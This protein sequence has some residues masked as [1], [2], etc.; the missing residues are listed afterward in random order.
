MVLNPLPKFV[1]PD[2]HQIYA[3][4]ESTYMVLDVETTNKDKGAAVNKD[5]HLVLACWEI[6]HPNGHIESK[7]HFGDEW[8]QAEL[9]ADLERVDFVVAQNAKFELQWLSRCGVNLR[10]ILPF[11]TMLGAW[12]LDGNRTLPRHLDALATRYNLGVKDSLVK[13]LIHAGVC[14]SEIPRHWLLPYC[15]KDVTLARLVFQYLLRDLIENSLLHLCHTRNLTCAMLA[16]IEFNGMTLDPEAVRKEYNDTIREANDIK[17]QLLEL[18]GDVNL[19]SPKQLAVYLYETLRFKEPRGPDGLPI[20]TATGAPSTSADTLSLLEASTEE[21]V[22]FLSLYKRYNKLD[23]LLTKNLTFFQK[24]CEEAENA[25]FLGSFNQ[26]ITATHRLSS[27]GR[28]LLFR[29]EKKAKSVQFQNMPR[30]Y[31]GLFWSGKED[32]LIGE[33]DGAQL[34]FRVAADLGKDSVAYAE[35]VGGA[36]VHSNTARVLTDAGQ[37]T[38]RQDAKSRTFAPLYGGMGKTKPE[39]AYSEY[40]KLHY[41]GVSSTQRNWAL[42]V[43]T[44][45]RLVTP[46]GMIFYWPNAALSRSGYVSFSTEIYNYPVQ[47]FATGE[48]IPIAAVCF[49]YRSEGTRIVMLNTIHDSLVSRIHKDE[50]GLFEELSKQCLTHD[51]YAYLRG[52][53][54]YEFH[55]PLGVEVK[56]GRNWGQGTG[57]T[58]SVFPDGKE[59]K[60]TK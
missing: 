35:I 58:Y 31:K 15:E 37:P 50:V 57:V 47:G 52:I 40:F 54:K 1:S 39:K 49:W 25:T 56:V 59:I 60:K 51:V 29:G 3:N 4:P 48:I 46:Y 28:P 34:E 8:D 41:E 26:G 16:D 38:S 20:R 44:N 21:Q 53:Y 36:D 5:N 17:R 10:K 18:V 43:A 30:Q 22:K 24:V 13:L 9:L 33:C 19:D 27:S 11:C 6:V 7:Y 42:Q 32:Y 12:V 55:V 14:P 2:Y 23:A 45:K